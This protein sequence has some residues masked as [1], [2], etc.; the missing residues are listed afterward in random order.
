MKCS[1]FVN[2]STLRILGFDITPN[3]FSI[4]FMD[5]RKVCSFKVDYSDNTVSKL[6]DTKIY[7]DNL[8]NRCDYFIS[9]NAF[10]RVFK[11]EDN[12]YI[13]TLIKDN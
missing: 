3:R 1:Y 8:K 9:T 10:I 4:S 7:H 2:A 12:A 11:A 5:E 6:F 13:Y